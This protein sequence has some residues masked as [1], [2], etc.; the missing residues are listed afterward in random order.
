MILRWVLCLIF[1]ISVAQADVFKPAYLQLTQTDSEHYDVLWK[2]PALDAQTSLKV[3]LEFPRGTQELQPRTHTYNAGA[4][5]QRWKIKIPGG[6]AE[7][8]IIF[9]NL[10]TTGADVIVRVE[11]ED[12]SEQLER[13]IATDPQFLFTASPGSL[14]LVTTYS[15]LG[16]EHILEGIDHLL[17]VLSLVLII[18]GKRRLFITITAFTAA[19][20]ITLT[21]ATLGIIHI[22][23]APVEAMIA[24]SIVF[25]A[26]EIIRQQQG[27]TSLMATR[28][29]IVAFIIGLLHGLGFASALAEIGLPEK[30][31]PL[32]LLFF[33]VGVELGQLIFIAGILVVML[34][35]KKVFQPLVKER[36]AILASAYVIGGISSYWFIER[37]ASLLPK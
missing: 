31:I 9:D 11:R 27:H 2:V 6:L 20:S 10:M 36:I 21:L 26:L 13:V 8:P 16:F 22:P 18:V 1:F 14:D 35:M 25:V 29:W 33:N 30:A 5:S 4:I 23:S 15:W 37:I 3:Y 24:L 12:G 28:P 7:K 34:A 32:A 17:F 19:H